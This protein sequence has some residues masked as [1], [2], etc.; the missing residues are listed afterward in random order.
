M[1]RRTLIAGLGS[2]AA[3]PLVAR[4][5]PSPVQVIGYLGAGEAESDRLIAAPPF[6]K[7]LSESGFVEGQNVVI[8]RRYAAGQYA[9]LSDLATDLVRRRVSVIVAS[10]NTDTARA[11]SLATSTIPVLFMV[12]SD[13]VKIGLV[14]SLNRPGGN[15]TGVNYFLTEL[16]A[17]RLQLL[18]QL[19]P[20][21]ATFGALIN[22]TAASADLNKNETALAASTNGL[23]VEFGPARDVREIENAFSTFANKNV[24]GLLVLPDTFFVNQRFQIASLAAR[25]GIPTIYTVREYV[26][27]GGLASYGP[28]LRESY[29]QLGVYAGRI[30]KGAKPAEL[31]VVQ[32]TKIEFVI[33]L[34]GARALGLRLPSSLL[35]LADE[36]IE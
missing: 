8:E 15:A 27:A 22:P 6:A 35:A 19:I 3:W 5:Q 4:G 23:Q 36:V 25:H 7:G 12:S 28:D 26:Q 20:A 18:H 21:A 30:L 34:K 17:K 16:T 31:P 33:N 32:S 11:A 13:P 29:R 14:A 24:G 1:K 9:R 2:A 10:P